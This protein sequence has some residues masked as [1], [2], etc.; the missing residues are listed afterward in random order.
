MLEERRG[1][2]R[3]DWGYLIVEEENELRCGNWERE[4][5]WLGEVERGRGC[6]RGRCLDRVRN[7]LSG[8]VEVVE[9]SGVM[10]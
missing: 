5:D 10:G 8:G 3:R 6:V 7:P 1:D 2:R 9:G 4:L